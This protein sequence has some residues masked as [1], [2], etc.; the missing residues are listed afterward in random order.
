MLEALAA[1]DREGAS[2]PSKSESNMYPITG[3]MTS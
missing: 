3:D 1:T 2:A